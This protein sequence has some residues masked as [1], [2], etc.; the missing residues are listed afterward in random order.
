MCLDFD[1][2]RDEQHLH[3]KRVELMED[4]LTYCL[5][6]SQSGDGIKTL[7]RIPKDAKNHKKYFKALEKYYECDEFDTSCKN[8]SRVCYESYDPDIYINELSSVWKDMEKETEFVTK[9]K[10]TIKIS[11]SN[12]IIRR[13]SLWWDKKYGMVQGKKNN[14]LFI[15]ASALNEFGVNQDEAFSTLNS[16]DSTGEKSS[17]IMAIVRSA[18]KNISGHNT[19]FYEDIDKT[20]EIANNI[21]MGVPI[22]E[23]KDSNKDVDVD[24]VAKTV[25]FNEFWI[26]NSKGKIDLV[27]HLFRLYLQDNGFYKYYPVGSNNFVF[28][29]VIDNTISD[30]NEE[31]IKDFV[32]D[33]LLGIDDMSV[34]NFFALN[35]KFFQETF[36]NYV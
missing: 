13:L 36:L 31:M 19:K 12:E 2:F 25:D 22:A 23:I 4:E 26:K 3:S 24:E 34:Y 1:G 33:Y 32:L 8:I 21:K 9:S 15:L 18:Y 11:D 14:N 7:V 28:V 35:T 20:S 29:R 5:F 10:A 27:P 16:Y 17:E 6:T 30:V